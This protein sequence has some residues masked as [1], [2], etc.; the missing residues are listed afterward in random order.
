[1]AVAVG[2]GRAQ[3]ADVGEKVVRSV[4]EQPYPM[5]LLA[6]MAGYVMGGGLFSR[7]TRP[8]ARAAMGALLVPG[9][10]ERILARGTEAVGA[11]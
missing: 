7:V 8:L 5:L 1:M 4:Q 9:F 2:D 3:L 10:R 11:A 6:A